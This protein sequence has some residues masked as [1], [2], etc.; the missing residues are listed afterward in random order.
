MPRVTS[1]TLITLLLSLTALGVAA[2]VIL[3]PRPLEQTTDDPTI[4]PGAH[5]SFGGCYDGDERNVGNRSNGIALYKSGIRGSIMIGP[6]CPV[7]TYPPDPTCADKPYSTLVVVFRTSDPVHAVLITTSDENGAFTADAPPGD[8]IV[9]AGDGTM[10][11]CKQ[12]TV[13]VPPRGYATLAIACD[14]GIR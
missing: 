14:S 9:G 6:S 7:E 5:C 2:Y 1:K 13:T 4:R 3:S 11:T 8:Y 12:G 10:P